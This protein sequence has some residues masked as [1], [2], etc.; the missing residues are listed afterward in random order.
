MGYGNGIVDWNT[1]DSSM[2]ATADA[3]ESNMIAKKWKKT[4]AEM[5]AR[6]QEA[7]LQ[8]NAWKKTARRIAKLSTVSEHQIMQ[9]L[10]EEDEKL[11][12]R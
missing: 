6:C 12:M 10:E 4:A 9:I 5:Q 11:R 2:A 1:A 3:I 8:R 7:I